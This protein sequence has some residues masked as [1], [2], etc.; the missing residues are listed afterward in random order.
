MN[1]VT[2]LTPFQKGAISEAEEQG[3][4]RVDGEAIPF[5]GGKAMPIMLYEHDDGRIDKMCIRGNGS[6]V[7]QTAYEQGDERYEMIRGQLQRARS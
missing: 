2:E 5:D 4:V 7:N 3:W 6:R 1:F